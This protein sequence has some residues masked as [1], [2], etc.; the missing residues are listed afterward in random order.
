MAKID[1]EIA[2][3]QRYLDRA[4]PHLDPIFDLPA[5]QMR[6][7]RHVPTFVDGRGRSCGEYGRAEEFPPGGYYQP[8][9]VVRSK[10]HCQLEPGHGGPHRAD[11]HAKMFGE[12]RIW[13][14]VSLQPR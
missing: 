13:E 14:W 1:R 6:W 12:H 4:T 7:V 11:G 5:A 9:I 3:A 2:L 10:V 8:S